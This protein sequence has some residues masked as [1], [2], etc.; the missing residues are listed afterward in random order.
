[1]AERVLLTP[2]EMRGSSEKQITSTKCS[3]W[4]GMF[5]FPVFF[6]PGLF[7]C[8]LQHVGAKS[9][10]W[11]EFAAFWT[12]NICC[13]VFPGLISVCVCVSLIVTV[14]QL[15]CSQQIEQ[16]A[17]TKSSASL[18]YDLLMQLCFQT[19]NPL[20]LTPFLRVPGD[21]CSLVDQAG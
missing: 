5:F 6:C 8:Y 16:H 9:L 2:P 3:P 13:Y 1:M 17:S 14:S 4:R 20:F 10:I 12:L 21:A 19:S 11:T 18:S 7:L 15:R